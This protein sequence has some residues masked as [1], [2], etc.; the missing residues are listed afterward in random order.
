MATSPLLDDHG[1]LAKQLYQM[2]SST[3]RMGK[4][5]HGV[6][7]GLSLALIGNASG[8]QFSGRQAIYPRRFR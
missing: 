3:D 6:P 4:R 2:L 5:P 7:D 8:K 1:V